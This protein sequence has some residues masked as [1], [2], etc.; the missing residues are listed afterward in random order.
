[1]KYRRSIYTRHRFERNTG[2]EGR[3]VGDVK[4][5]E[6]RDGD[7]VLKYAPFQLDSRNCLSSLTLERSQ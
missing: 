1:M 6:Q 4:N 3:R 5:V 2:E 7:T